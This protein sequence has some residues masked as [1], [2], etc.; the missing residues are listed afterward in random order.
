MKFEDILV[1][2]KG[3]GRFQII[4]VMISFLG[5][6][7]LPCHFLLNNFIAAIPS[8]HCDISLLED[9]GRYSNLS[10]A[11][12]LVVGIPVR[13]DGTPDSCRMFLEPQYQLLMNSSNSSGALT[14][15]CQNG[16]VYDNSTFKSTLTSEVNFSSDLIMLRNWSPEVT[17][18]PFFLVKVGPG[19]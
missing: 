1:A 2:V 5:R 4:I 6:F 14:V 10:Q 17:I 18:F 16:W 7:S 15:P 8:H 12:K 19:V 11:E 9:G 13:E 3:F